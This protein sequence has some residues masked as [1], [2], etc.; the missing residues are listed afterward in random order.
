MKEKWIKLISA[1]LLLA[2]F[3]IVMLTIHVNEAQPY[4]L[5]LT[6]VVTAYLGNRY[7][8]DK[9]ATGGDAK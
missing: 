3:A 1:R 9:A 7:F 6:A 4:C 8:T 2:A 5:A